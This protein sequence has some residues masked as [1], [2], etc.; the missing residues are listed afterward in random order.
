MVAA[1]PQGGRGG[2]GVAAAPEA[3][4]C[5]TPGNAATPEKQPPHVPALKPSH[6]CF[7]CNSTHPCF[8]DGWSA[9]IPVLR[10]FSQ[11]SSL[12]CSRSAS[13]DP[14]FVACWSAVIPFYAADRPA[15][16]RVCDGSTRM[17]GKSR[18]RSV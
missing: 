18:D 11:L 17:M 1:V 10:R 14:C 2:T 16:I 4:G 5:R 3:R 7:S 6:A 13:C 9:V 15:V 8:V 12:V